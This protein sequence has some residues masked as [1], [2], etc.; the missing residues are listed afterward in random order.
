MSTFLVML[1]L[2]EVETPQTSH[3]PE[4][5]T[6]HDDERVNPLA[7]VS[8]SHCRAD[9]GTANLRCTVTEVQYSVPEIP[10]AEYS[11]NPWRS[12]APQAD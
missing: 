7:I 1:S 2:L 6:A 8:S 3:R 11:V 9:S 10:M 5:F 12:T 4:K